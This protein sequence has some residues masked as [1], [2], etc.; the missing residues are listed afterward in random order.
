MISSLRFDNIPQ[1]IFPNFGKRSQQGGKRS[2]IIFPN[3]ILYLISLQS[4]PHLFPYPTTHLTVTSNLTRPHLSPNI[5]SLH[6][7]QWSICVSRSPDPPKVNP[8]GGGCE[9]S[10]FKPLTCCSLMI[11]HPLCHTAYHSQGPSKNGLCLQLN[12]LPIVTVSHSHHLMTPS[13]P[14][15][16]ITSIPIVV[17]SIGQ[18]VSQR[19]HAKSSQDNEKHLKNL[20]MHH[21]ISIYKIFMYEQRT[22]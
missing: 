9:I 19:S 13:C 17:H 8:G 10:G 21:L 2:Y 11:S 22:Q 14:I 16:P 12:H 7:I 4:T 6:M 1:C 5:R 3:L 15:R 18:T 20:Q